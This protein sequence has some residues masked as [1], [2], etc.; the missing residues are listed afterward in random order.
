MLV[1]G[2]FLNQGNPVC[3]GDIA[4][5]CVRAQILAEALPYIRKF[6]GKT[7]VIKYGG[8]AMIDQRLKDAVISDVVLTR[9]VGMNPVLIH[10]GGPEIT[11]LMDKVGKK[12]AFV[13]GLRVTDEETVELAEM[14]LAGK[15]NK[16]LVLSIN[17]MGAKA[18]GLS[19]KDGGLIKARKRLHMTRGRGQSGTRTS[20]AAPHSDSDSA[21]ASTVLDLGFV[22]DI[23][24]VNPDIIY[25]VTSAGYIPVI[26]PTGFGEFGESYN[27][28]ADAAAGSLAASL[29]AEKLILLTDVPGVCR[30]VN[31]G[32]SLISELS[33]AEARGLI[34]EGIASSGMIPKIEACLTAVEGGVRGAHIVDG[35]VPHAILLELFTDRGIGTMIS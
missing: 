9:F 18:V 8:N 34:E 23:V 11:T 22:G 16:E 31:D 19:G 10:G 5:L 35:R 12:P 21:G 15:I 2:G 28:N 13:D 6:H 27:I 17:R 4:E 24:E 32:E 7:L 20:T 30:R 1:S 33:T 26:A 3:G 29:K 14:A 25:T